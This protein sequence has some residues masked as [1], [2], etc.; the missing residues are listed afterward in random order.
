[1]LVFGNILK[2]K[3]VFLIQDHSDSKTDFYDAN[4]DLESPEGQDFDVVNISPASSLTHQSRDP[5]DASVKY[6]KFILSKSN[7]YSQKTQDYVV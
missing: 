6:V 2:L 7:D 3:L 4:L 1:M 5:N